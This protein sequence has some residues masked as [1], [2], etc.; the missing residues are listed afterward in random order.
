MNWQ[1]TIIYGALCALNYFLGVWVAIRWMRKKFKPLG[2][3]STEE[4]LT[5][6]YKRV[7]PG[8]IPKGEYCN[9]NLKGWPC[10][11]DMKRMADAIDFGRTH[12]RPVKI[13]WPRETQ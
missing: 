1:F 13:V 8:P 7:S 2:E 4:I 6:F 9:I 5:E 12:E 11:R 3:H 10:D